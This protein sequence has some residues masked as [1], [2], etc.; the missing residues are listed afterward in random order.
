MMLYFIP[1][2]ERMNSPEA[3]RSVP[4]V[5]VVIHNPE[6]NILLLQKSPD[7]KA[8]HLWELPGGKMDLRM[9][10]DVNPTTI[11]ST[12][13]R[14]VAEETTI[15]LSEANLRIGGSFDYGFSAKGK[16][17]QR[18]VIMVH[19]QL[20]TV[21]EVSVGSLQTAEGTSEDKHSRYGWF[22]PEEIREMSQ[23]NKLSGNSNELSLVFAKP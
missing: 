12:A 1:M 17:Y 22:S 23:N 2:V 20:T 21:P 11:R 9:Q 4:T 13:V 14:E 3:P 7:S 19:A 10:Q 18:K 16:E 15:A 8:A 5:R 6:G